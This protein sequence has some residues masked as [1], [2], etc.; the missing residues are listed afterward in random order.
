MDN[1]ELEK[2]LITQLN[3]RQVIDLEMYPNTILRPLESKKYIYVSRNEQGKVVSINRGK[4][5]IDAV[6]KYIRNL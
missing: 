3:S 5:F 2:T 4:R 6:E 1:L